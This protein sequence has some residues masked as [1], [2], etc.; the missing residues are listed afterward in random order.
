M[1]AS[2]SDVYADQVRTASSTRAV[3]ASSCGTRP[4]MPLPDPAT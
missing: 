2:A 4:T 3:C 1:Y